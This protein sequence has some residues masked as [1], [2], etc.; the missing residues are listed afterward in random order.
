[1]QQGH[2]GAPAANI[3]TPRTQVGVRLR[4]TDGVRV[5]VRVR[6]RAGFLSEQHLATVCRRDR[7]VDE[8]ILTVINRHYRY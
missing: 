8:L 3:K 5:R 2:L 7:D 4:V 1:M 6:V